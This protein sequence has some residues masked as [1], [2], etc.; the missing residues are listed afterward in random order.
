MNVRNIIER[1]PNIDTDYIDGRELGKRGTI[2]SIR[3]NE[4]EAHSF[5]IYGTN[6]RIYNKNILNIISFTHKK[7]NRNIFGNNSIKLRPFIAETKFHHSLKLK[8]LVD[9]LR[10]NK[11]KKRIRPKINPLD[12]SLEDKVDDLLKIYNDIKSI[13]DYIKQHQIVYWD[14]INYKRIVNHLGTDIELTTYRVFFGISIIVNNKIKPLSISEKVGKV[15]GYELIENGREVDKIVSNISE[16][17]KIASVAKSPLIGNHPCILGS[18]ISA[19]LIHEL[20]GHACEGDNIVSRVS[21]L[22]DSIGKRIASDDI[23][24]IDEPNKYPLYSYYLYDDEGNKANR[25]VVI[26]RGV[27]KKVLTDIE[28]SIIMGTKPTANSRAESYKYPPLTRQS[29]F[30]LLPGDYD[31]TELFKEANKGVYGIGMKHAY[32][33]IAKG[34]LSAK[35]EL[36]WLISKGEPSV[37]IMGFAITGYVYDFLKNIEAISK[38]LVFTPIFCV[39]NDQRLDVTIG[40]AHLL[41]NRILIGG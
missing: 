23:T 4:V 28:T 26:E 9:R 39:K 33:D 40:A 17:A 11:C 38:D 34:I 27:F 29:I 21:F 10:I 6:I 36:G 14:E 41:L 35:S 7:F 8:D 15:S 5:E 20:I 37:P 16:K 32:V 25:T 19:L 3:N 31:K 2:I 1:I 18:E 24:I 13:G 22:K 12:V 30:Y